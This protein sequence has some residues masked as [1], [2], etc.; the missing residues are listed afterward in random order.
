MERFGMNMFEH[1]KL[2]PKTIYAKAL[3]HIFF[4]LSLTFS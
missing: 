2:T 1:H 3:P 4:S